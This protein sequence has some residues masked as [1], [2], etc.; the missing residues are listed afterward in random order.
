MSAARL[1]VRDYNPRSMRLSCIPVSLYPDL[2]SARLT[3][4]GWFRRAAELGLNGADLS[5]AHVTSRASAY[6]DDLKAEAQ[7]AG[8][9]IA[10]IAT[11]TDFTRPTSDERESQIDDL[12]QW[13]DAAARLG[14]PM[15]RVTAG[16]A[17][18]GV[19][20]TDGLKWAVAGLTACLDHAKA[21]GVQLLYENHGRGAVWSYDDFTRPAARFLE[22]VR[23]T[24][25][26][27]LRVLFDTA[28]NLALD[29]D[30]RE[31]FEQVKHRVGAMHISDFRRRGTH[32]PVVIGTGV[33]P[34]A[35]I[36]R[37]LVAL[38]Y[39]GWISIEEASKTG[40][41]AFSTAVQ[42]VDR[43]WTD[44]GGQ[45]RPSATGTSRAPSL[46]R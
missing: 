27:G 6:L 30:P 21:A 46:P 13:I 4:G 20:D 25:G 24:E 44:A 28:N 34:I 18:P 19:A 43:A 40:P 31:V 3:L 10:M 22:V 42:F 2:A 39:D 36:L 23:R 8:V 17:H 32:E 5:V 9:T 35:P 26:S 38:G 1:R 37:D 15:M 45:P 41:D 33:A 16:Q 29:E 11:Y 7:D 12:R 14:T